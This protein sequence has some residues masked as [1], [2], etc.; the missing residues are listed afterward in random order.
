VANRDFTADELGLEL[1]S[2]LLKPASAE[3]QGKTSLVIVADGLLW[4]L[5]FQA[6]QPS[7]DRYLIEDAAVSYA[8]SL[9]ALREM[10]KPK[11]KPTGATRAGLLLAFGN[12]S[13]GKETASRERSLLM[14]E[15]LEPLPESERQIKMLS[16]LYGTDRSRVYLQADATEERVKAEA[17][18]YRILHLATHGI[19]N[20]A[21]PMYSHVLL[22]Q[23][24]PGSKED[25]I[26]EA[27]ELMN[28]DMNADLVI[29][30]A[31]ETARG[32]IGTGEGVI[33]LTWA[34]FVAGCPT[35]VASQWKVEVESTTELMVEFHRNLKPEVDNPGSG[36]TKTKALRQAALKLLRSGQYRHPFYWAGFVIIGNGR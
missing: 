16:Q 3:I 28:L 24:E 21:S 2:L 20:D 15:K 35:A 26:L 32:R 23:P 13:I 29:L 5:P 11:R 6:L 9:T 4:G 10:V 30:S 7:K 34:L 33:G 31:C 27:W 1:Y 14:D 12:P 17:G 19:L 8:P 22:S 25:G 18:N 36:M